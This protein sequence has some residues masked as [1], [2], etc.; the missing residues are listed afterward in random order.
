MPYSPEFTGRIEGWVVNF[1]TKNYWRV[2]RS[3]PRSDVMQEAYVVFLRVKRKY[4][5]VDAPYFMSLFKTAWTNHFTDMANADTEQRMFTE[6]PRS[7]S[8]DGDYELEPM[9]DVDN[10]GQLATMLRQ[11]PAEVT[12]VLT[13]LLNAPQELLD[14]ALSSWN[15]AD[16]RCKAGGSKRICQMLGLP[17][18]LDV[19]KQVDDYFRRS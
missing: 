18:T 13:L 10:D 6:M 3:T 11:A 16:K 7:R 2:S 9:G 19:M 14:V 15:G 1:L 4:P 12:Q 5:N 17:E 8:E